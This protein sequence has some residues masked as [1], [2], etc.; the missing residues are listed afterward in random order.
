MVYPWRPCRWHL[1]RIYTH[2]LRDEWGK[3]LGPTK[4]N[5]N[6][7]GN[8]NAI[9]SYHRWGTKAQRGKGTYPSSPCR[10][11][12]GA[13]VNQFPIKSP[14]MG[15]SRYCTVIDKVISSPM[16]LISPDSSCHSTNT[17]YSHLF[18][19]LV[20]F[21]TCHPFSLSP[22]LGGVYTAPSAWIAFLQPSYPSTWLMFTHFCT[23]VRYK[24]P[25]PGRLPWPSRAV[26]CPLPCAL[27]ARPTTRI[28]QVAHCISA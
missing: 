13:Q 6:G 1:M 17:L 16:L 7:T 24:P 22:L 23:Q 10:T 2:P 20:I 14:W 9:A 26:R 8:H 19:P 12:T 5:Q 4:Q 28:I 15:G 18:D 27:I 3:N 11:K 25:L 21:R